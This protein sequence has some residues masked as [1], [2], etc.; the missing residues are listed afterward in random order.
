MED[1]T[2]ETRLASLEELIRRMEKGSMTLEETLE[3]YEQ[4]M[5]AAV[6]LKKQL[7]TA[8]KRMLELSG[9]ELKPM[10]EAP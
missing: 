6:E 2:F 5:K 8:E 4:G 3:A 1:Q 10:E 7:E 9:G